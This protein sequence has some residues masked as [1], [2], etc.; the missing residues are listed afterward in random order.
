[1]PDFLLE[2]G[3][4]E[5]PARMIDGAREELARRVGDLLQRERL[6]ENPAVQAFSTP[7]RLAVVTT[8][9][10]ASQPDVR[11]QVTGPSL[12]VAYKDGAPTAAAEAFARKLNIPVSALEKI[13]TA[14]G[15]YLAATVQKKGRPAAEILAESL[16]KEIAGIYWAKSMY[17]RSKSAERFVRPVRWIVSLLDGEVVPVEFAGVSAGRA[18]QGHRI[19][20][21]GSVAIDRPADYAAALAK[22]YVTVSSAE[23]EQR[24]RK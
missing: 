9:I 22:S 16:P 17:W 24:I 11:E 7:R 19:L 23:R 10:S 20:S 4:E 14:K 13:S 21:N 18:S 15:E 3:T 5:I 2:I 12:K 1:M 6:A 8:G